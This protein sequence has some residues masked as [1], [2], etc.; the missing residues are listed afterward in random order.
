MKETISYLSFFNQLI[1]KP[2]IF[3]APPAALIKSFPLF[4]RNENNLKIH[5]M[6][7]D[8]ISFHY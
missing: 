7:P 1:P 8:E 6:Y 2:Y 4:L 5:H 3:L